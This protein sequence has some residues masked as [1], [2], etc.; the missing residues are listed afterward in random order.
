M[1]TTSAAIKQSVVAAMRGYASLKAALTGGIHEGFAPA[2][3]QTYP[4]LTYNLVAAP[5]ADTWDSRMIVALLDVFIHAENPVVANNVDQL[6][7]EALD[8]VTLSVTGQTNLI[9]YRVTDLPGAVSETAEGKK[10]YQV[11][12]SYE[13]WTD[14]PLT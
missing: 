10:F 13:V 1:A 12:G 2:K 5:Y 7:L 4:L 8:R 3:V 11:G 14:Q 9:C 6:V